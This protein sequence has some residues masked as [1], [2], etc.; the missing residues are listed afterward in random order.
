MEYTHLIGAE[1]VQNAANS[2]SSSA[3]T[4]QRAANSIENSLYDFKMFLEDW[5]A[6]YEEIVNKQ[7][8]NS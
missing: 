7:N 3:D 5:L 2:I 6:R 4:M 8:E 1:K